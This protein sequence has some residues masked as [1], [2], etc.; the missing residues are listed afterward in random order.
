MLR[1]FA[2]LF[3][4]GQSG[5]AQAPDYEPVYGLPRWA[6]ETW[7][8]HNPQFRPEYEMLEWLARNP[9]L[10]QEYERAR[11]QGLITRR[12]RGRCVDASA[13]RPSSGAS[14]RRGAAD[15]QP[16]QPR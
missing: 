8:A 13:V 10:R 7:L 4:F 1:W 11:Q 2:K 14:E 16:G 15:A 3:G 5:S 6:V 9:P 12:P